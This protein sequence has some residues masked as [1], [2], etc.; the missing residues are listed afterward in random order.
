MAVSLLSPCKNTSND[1]TSVRDNEVQFQELKRLALKTNAD[2]QPSKVELLST[3]NGEILIVKPTDEIILNGN[4]EKTVVCNAA[5]IVQT[6]SSSQLPNRVSCNGHVL[7]DGAILV[8]ANQND[9][10]FISLGS[11]KNKILYKTLSGISN[12]KIIPY[13]GYGFSTHIG[14]WEINLSNNF[15]D[16]YNY[17][18]SPKEQAAGRKAENVPDKIC[19]HSC[20]SGGEGA[21]QCAISKS[22]FGMAQSCSVKCEGN[23]YPCCIN[24]LVKCKCCPKYPG[25]APQNSEL[26][27]DVPHSH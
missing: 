23:F 2:F 16:A 3:K 27:Q 15:P 10:C 7:Y 25:Q 22:Y 26:E 19:N 11:K 18:M 9:L 6:D 4:K 5:Y 17:L 24:D 20:T 1:R 14:K 12:K 13:F 21:T 8:T